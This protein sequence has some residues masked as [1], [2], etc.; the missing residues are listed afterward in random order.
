MM[1]QALEFK[2]KWRDYQ[3]RVLESELW[4][5]NKN[6]PITQRRSCLLLDK[7]LFSTATKLDKS[8]FTPLLYPYSIPSSLPL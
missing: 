5:T 4:E 3:Q 7:L 6:E 2:G 8:G 1:L